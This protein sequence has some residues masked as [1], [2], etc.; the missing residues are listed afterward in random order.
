L[1]VM[2]LGL[3]YPEDSDDELYTRVHAHMYRVW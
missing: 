2:Q 3:T 1:R